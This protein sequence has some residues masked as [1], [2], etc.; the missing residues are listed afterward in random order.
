MDLL[1]DRLA[2]GSKYGFKVRF[3]RLFNLLSALRLV[4]NGLGRVSVCT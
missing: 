3:T 4:L 1:Q 2:F